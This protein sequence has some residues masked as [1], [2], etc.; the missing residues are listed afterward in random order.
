[1][2]CFACLLSQ[3]ILLDAEIVM[4]N[5]IEMGVVVE[6]RKS[7]RYKMTEEQRNR[8]YCSSISRSSTCIFLICACKHQRS[9]LVVARCDDDDECNYYENSLNKMKRVPPPPLSSP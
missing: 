2:L 4:M 1:M 9:M 7:E 6:Q 3:F 8:E 5:S